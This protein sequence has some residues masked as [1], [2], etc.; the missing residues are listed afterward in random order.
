M[1]TEVYLVVYAATVDES[2]DAEQ[3]VTDSKGIAAALVDHP[4]SV[5]VANISAI[6]LSLGVGQLA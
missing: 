3:V 6:T 1:E 5:V 4:V 2:T